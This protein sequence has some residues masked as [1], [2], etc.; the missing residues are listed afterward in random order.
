MQ[1]SILFIDK[2][3]L[4]PWKSNEPIR[5]VEL[6]NILLMRD[7]MRLGHPLTLVADRSWRKPLQDHL[8]MR[9]P[10]CIWTPAGLPVYLAMIWVAWRFL[11][12]RYHT[13]LVGNVGNGLI[14]GLRLIK[15]MKI[16]RQ[17]VL[18]AH[19]ESSPRFARVFT[20]WEGHVLAVNG[21]IARRFQEAG[22][23][24][25]RVDYGI[26]NADSFFPNADTDEK[27]P[28][29]FCVLGALDN[30]WKGADTAIEA[31][32][33][34]PE[35]IKNRCRLHLASYQS[36]RDMD[37]SRI[38]PHPWMPAVQIPGFLRSMQVLIVPSRDEEV[39]RETFSQA[40]VQGMLTGLP[41]LHSDL[42]ILVEKFDAGGGAS[43][44][45]SKELAELME[46]SVCDTVWRHSQGDKARAVALERYVWDTKRFVQRYI[47]TGASPTQDTIPFISAPVP[48]IHAHY[49]GEIAAAWDHPDVRET[50]GRIASVIDDGTL[51]TQAR[52]R[53]MH[54]QWTLGERRVDVAVKAF[55]R[56][57]ALKDR[58]D[59]SRGSK[60]SRSFQT[61]THLQAHGVGTPE[62]VAW[63]DRWEGSRLTESYYLCVYEPGLS[64][65]REE[66]IQLYRHEPDCEKLMHLL[67][68]AAQGLARLHACG[69]AH[70]DMGN[71]NI[72]LRRTGDV[73]WGD[74]MFIDL[75]RARPG[76]VG[77]LRRR[78]RDLSRINL[79]SDFLRVFIAMYGGDKE[80]PQK[81]Y[82][83]EATFRRR[84]TW[85]TRTR[86]WRHPLR[87]RQ[88]RKIKEPETIVYPHPKDI[89]IWDERSGQAI[90]VM[91]RRER[92]RYYS[93]TA[94]WSITTSTIKALPTVHH[95]FKT[96]RQASFSNP[97]AMQNRVGMTLH[98]RPRT[99][100]TER[101]W[102]TALGVMPLLIRFYHHQTE[103]EW[104]FTKQCIQELRAM[105]Y[106]VSIAMVQDRQAVLHPAHWERFVHGIMEDLAPHIEWVEIGHA[107]NR[108]K[109]G[110]WNIADYAR[111]CAPFRRYQQNNG[112][113]FMGPATIDFEYHYTVAALHQ[114]K[115]V[116]QLDALSHHLYVDRRGAPENKQGSFDTTDK[117]ALLKAIASRHTRSPGRVIVSEVNWPLI[118]TGV[119]SPV[120]SPY[121]VPGARSNDPSVSEQAY[122]AYM[123][124]YLL[125]T[126]SSGHVERVYWWRLA[127]HGYGLISD[128]HEPW[129]ARPAYHALKQFYHVVEEATF[130]NRSVSPEHVYTYTFLR[131]D[132]ER[133]VLAYA[134]PGPATY[135]PS[136]AF[137][138]IQNQLGR[139]IPGNGPAWTLDG[140]V[141][142]FRRVTE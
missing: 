110:L 6:F 115:D 43:F 14:P 89:W 69:M 83:F 129:R 81:L 25:V 68:C 48:F 55:G 135:S 82:D 60:A 62:P 71:Q 88:R 24:R 126:L 96:L 57:T 45:T 31:F 11:S 109:W 90:S 4:K 21:V 100:D 78:A 140:D 29:H 141:L 50:L 61:A 105:G 19:R 64:A 67:Q 72:A 119:F 133:V 79:P 120:C 54:V 1:E 86:A 18:I 136:F 27:T 130:I 9:L 137:E 97:V 139:E 104:A 66:L 102:I 98:P 46:K 51:L 124:R 16:C 17:A 92:K 142:Y 103:Q 138:S 112:P 132:G 114:L 111:L 73:T 127:A 41:V 5:G 40:T 94:S 118:D 63:L 8:G 80:L 107:I 2:V 59:R 49:T 15:W 20:K 87:T 113:R 95:D 3:L 58:L 39:M 33:L 121:I 77:S 116:M 12:S 37:D 42:P 99:W 26:H 85:H 35:Q 106:S 52:H 38:V 34:L 44:R 122:G 131:T 101:S 28:L 74:V 134:H 47:I 32:H 22:C 56:Q 10:E 108:V 76:A 91:T 65:F 123:I 93:L 75:N 53:V 36:P 84:Y 117:S 23:A 125:M 13:L 30:P 70:G 7:L 128:Q